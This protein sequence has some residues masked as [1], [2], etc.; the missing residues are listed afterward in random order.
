MP[1]LE[2]LQAKKKQIDAQIQ[3]LRARETRQARARDTR[4]KVVLGSAV[5]KLIE[6]GRLKFDDL[7]NELS[8]R[9]RKLFDVNDRTPNATTIAA[10]N[11]TKFE[12]MTLDEAAGLA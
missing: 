9:D 5:L 3:A 8:A 12:T 2:A 4:R 11:E 10:M 7:V 6:D 1:R